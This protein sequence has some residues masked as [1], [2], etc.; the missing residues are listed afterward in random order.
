MKFFK[1]NMVL[2]CKNCTWKTY[3]NLMYLILLQNYH[4][5]QR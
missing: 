3:N 1:S 2:V 5:K 4:F